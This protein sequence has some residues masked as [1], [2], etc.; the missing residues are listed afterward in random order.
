V[1][2]LLLPP[3]LAKQ[4]VTQHKASDRKNDCPQVFRG[5]LHPDEQAMIIGAPPAI[6]TNQ[7]E[8]Q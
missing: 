5:H 3:L 4:F 7:T 6:N 8:H 2:A 1:L